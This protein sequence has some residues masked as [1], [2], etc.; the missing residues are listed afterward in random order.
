MVGAR[1]VFVDPS[2]RRQRRVRRMG[3]LLVI[4]AAGYAALLLS[5]AFG[6]PSFDSPYLP[7]PAGG[8]PGA[9][10]TRPAAPTT[11]G[12]THPGAT[13]APGATGTGAPTAPPTA[14]T[15]PAAAPASGV[16]RTPSATASAPTAAPTATHGRSSAT[17]PV[18]T[19][20]GRGHG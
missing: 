18:P 14:A 13:G 12:R 11:A 20:T 7:L 9:A 1:P 8:G 2:G 15:R 19:H 6:G 10:S 5:A 4:P 3:R 17:H 16:R